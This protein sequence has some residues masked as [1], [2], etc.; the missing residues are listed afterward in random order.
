[1]PATN[2]QRPLRVHGAPPIMVLNSRYDVSTPYQGAQHVAA[3][4]PGV[5]VTYDGMG[6][7]AVTRGRCAA[8]LVYH[9]LSERRLPPPDTHC[10]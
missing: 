8:G 6:H 1:V 7:G 10:A 9:Y 5:M 4:L 3:Q 2:P